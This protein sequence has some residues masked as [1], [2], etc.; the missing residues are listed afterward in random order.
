MCQHGTPLHLLMIH[1]EDLS[2]DIKYAGQQTNTDI[3]IQFLET[4]CSQE[5]VE[6]V[7]LV[8][9][10]GTKKIARVWFWTAK[11]KLQET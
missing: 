3:N 5:L 7:D 4:I 8:L 2:K 10:M 6:I 9:A 1:H 11:N